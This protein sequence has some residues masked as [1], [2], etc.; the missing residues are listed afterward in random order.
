VIYLENA[1]KKKKGR[2]MRERE[3]S[4]EEE[5]KMPQRSYIFCSF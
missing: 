2:G 5:K 4:Y 1:K 3:E